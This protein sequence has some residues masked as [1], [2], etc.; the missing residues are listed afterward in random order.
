MNTALK[1]AR[2]KVGKTQTQVAGESNVAVRLYQYYET[3]QKTPSVTTA[4]RLA[5]ALGSTV[6]KLF[7][8]EERVAQ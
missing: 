2:E 6:E 4:L 1:A 5:K 8:E 7:P 3:G